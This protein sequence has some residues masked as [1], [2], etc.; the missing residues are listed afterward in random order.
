[1]KGFLK[2]ALITIALLGT[3]PPTIAQTVSDLL[4]N[5][6]L[7]VHSSLSPNEVIVPGQRVALTIEVAT[8]RW[9]TGGT[10]IRLPEVDGLVILQNEKFASNA[11]VTRNGHTWVVQRWTLDLYPQKTGSFRIPPIEMLIEVNV[12]ANKSITGYIA[13][14]AQSL[15]V[16]LPK[17]LEKT[18]FWVAA[19]FYS[20]TQKM[21]ADL[22]NLQIGDAVEREI[23]LKANGVMAMMLP[24]I[25]LE[26]VDGLRGYTTPPQLEDSNN[27]GKSQAIRI[28]HITYI[29]E[30]PGSYT[31]PAIDVFWWNTQTKKLA[32]VSLAETQIHVQGATPEDQVKPRDY[33]DIRIAL[34]ILAIIALGFIALKTLSA[35]TLYESILRL[36][37]GGQRAIAMVR[38][39]ALP[40]RLNP[41]NNE[42]D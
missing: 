37:Q 13:S 19:P 41:D 28:Q 36:W 20:M 2:I 39:P 9:F 1:M 32:V 34:A 35:R 5:G 4:A 3:A 38:K 14:T 21:N 33:I 10:R 40:S 7:T 27:R 11:T 16:S 18:P 23:T 15:N 24:V 42:R 22:Q 8:S 29:A 26:G 25:P 31:L 6:N 30:K 12:S 17:P